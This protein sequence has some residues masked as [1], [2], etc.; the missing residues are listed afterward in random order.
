MPAPKSPASTLD[1]QRGSSIPSSGPINNNPVASTASSIASPLALTP[2]ASPP[3]VLHGPS[4]PTPDHSIS[5]GGTWTLCDLELMH[6]YTASTSQTFSSIPA[7]RHVYK[8]VIT[9]LAFSNEFLLHEILALAAL[10]LSHESPERR[11]S[12][13]DNASKHHNVALPMFRSAF[14][15]LNSR[16]YQACSAFGTILTIYEWASTKHVSD[17]FFGPANSAEESTIEWVQLLRG[18][19]QIIRYSYEELLQGPLSPIL[20]WNHDA[21]IEADENPAERARFNAL[22]ELWDLEKLAVTTEEKEALNEALRWLKIIYTVL[23]NPNNDT[24]PASA[25]LSWPVRVSELFLLMAKQRHPAALILLS[26]FCLLLNKMEDFWW[27]RGM[28]RKLLHEI[29]QTIGA[30]WEPWIAWPLQDLV[31]CEFK[32]QSRSSSNV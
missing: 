17:L 8:S 29:H 18:S 9:K 14:Q 5:S 6:F 13:L 27:I 11:E 20:Q 24:D 1:S 12:L 26:H 21:E 25:A 30:E 32:Q 7:R 19:G 10:H 3:I 22:E 28:S 16:N 2:A 31:V 4:A 23:T 15:E